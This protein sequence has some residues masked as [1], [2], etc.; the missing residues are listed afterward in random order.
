MGFK[1]NRYNTCVANKTVYKKQ[2]TIAWYVDDNKIFHVDPK[3]VTGVVNKNEERFGKITITRG[4]QR[5]FLGMDITYLDN[6]TAAISMSVLVK[7]SIAELGENVN[8]TATS[9][10]KRDL[11]ENYEKS[12]MLK[13]SKGEIFHSIVAEL[14][15]VSHRGH[16]DIQ[17]SIAFLCNRISCNTKKDW[18][19]RVE[20]SFGVLEWHSGGCLNYRS[21]QF[22]EDE[23]MGRRLLR[24]AHGHEEPHGRRCILAGER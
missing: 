6:G 9:P 16:L 18:T 11:Y 20:A 14:L 15:Y 10:L 2:C 24:G 21:G 4:K 22:G 3:V 17:L 19:E 1:L 12:K 8:K 23:D 7:E 13:K 5:V